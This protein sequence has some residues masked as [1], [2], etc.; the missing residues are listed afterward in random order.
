MEYEPPRT[1][2]AP[3]TPGAQLDL[4]LQDWSEQ[5][6]EE[7]TKENQDISCQQDICVLDAMMDVQNSEHRDLQPPSPI[8]IPGYMFSMFCTVE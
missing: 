7:E 1:P 4:S 6:H 5:F 3:L 2:S 8:G